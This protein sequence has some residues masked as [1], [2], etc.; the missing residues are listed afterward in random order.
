VFL[1]SEKSSYHS[2]EFLLQSIN[3]SQEGIKIFEKATDEMSKK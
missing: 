3:A 2:R 1:F